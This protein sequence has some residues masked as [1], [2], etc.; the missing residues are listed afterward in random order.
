MPRLVSR[1]VQHHV[2]GPLERS[3]ALFVA[4]GLWSLLL[5][6]VRQVRR[7]W[8]T[9]ITLAAVVLLVGSSGRW[10]PLQ[11]LAAAAVAMVVWR[12]LWPESF[13]S[14]LV[15][16]G[17]AW[18]SRWWYYG[19]RWPGLARRH[20]LVVHDVCAPAG[21][22]GVL[23]AAP[24]VEIAE[25]VKVVWTPAIDRL[26]I[27]IPAGLDPSAFERAAVALAHATKSLDCRIRADR[28]GRVWVELLRRD[29]LLATIPALPIPK[30]V[31]LRAVPL[32]LREDGAVWTVQAEG[33][34]TVVVGRTGAGK[35]S[36][37]QGLLRGVA[38]AVA[39]GVVEPW[40]F[41]PKGGM[42]LALGRPMYARFFDGTPESMADG[43]EDCAALVRERAA[44]LAGVV[45]CHTPTAA[46]PLRL[47]V[48]DEL[49]ALTAFC[50]RRTAQRVEKA[51]GLI[52]TMG[53]AVG[54]VVWAF[55]QDPGKDVI[56]YRNLFPTRIALAL[57]EANEVDMVLKE[58]ARDRGARADQIPMSTPGVGYVRE[59]GN[60]D[61]IRVRAAYCTDEDIRATAVAYPWPTKENAT[62]NLTKPL[63]GRQADRSSAPADGGA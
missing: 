40:G 19:P 5:L 24:V 27:K 43:L 18:W 1:Q 55:L 34:H 46:A 29:P 52:L 7:F 36:I 53:R 2:L 4:L 59:D 20:G 47:V 61:P 12:W 57:G 38:P 15:P 56:A 41:D 44:E 32:G 11:P 6:M 63:I 33:T 28:P 16:F 26:L 54:V 50:D 17:R 42:E 10:A 39:S 30:T 49:A 60:P 51:L 37:L 45:R 8:R 23:M 25:L 48:I 31:N 3:G 13:R 14:R 21:T 62:L 22:G 9:S 35:A 58:G